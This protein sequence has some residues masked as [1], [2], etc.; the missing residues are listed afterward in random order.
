MQGMHVAEVMTG[1]TDAP[2]DPGIWYNSAKFLDLEY[3]TYGLVLPRPPAH[4]VQHWYEDERG[5]RGLRLVSD[6]NTGAFLGVN[7]MGM[8]GRHRQFESWIRDARSLEYVLDHLHVADFD[9]EFTRRFLKQ[10]RT[11]TPV[12]AG[13]AS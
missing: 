10:V 3:Q 1:Q 4:H 13:G 2:Y 9:P 8:R 7:L 11:M 6:A 12:T 5:G